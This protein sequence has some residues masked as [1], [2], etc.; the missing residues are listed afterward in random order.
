MFLFE[1]LLS[2]DCHFVSAIQRHVRDLASTFGN[3]CVFYCVQDSKASLRIGRQAN[4]GHS[5]LIMHLDY[6][7]STADG[8]SFSPA[9]R[10]Q[11]KPM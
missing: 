8:T 11:L 4:R 1:G 10:H 6:Q 9:V 2:S 7:T 3:D 5:P